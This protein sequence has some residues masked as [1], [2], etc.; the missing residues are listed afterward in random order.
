MGTT[1]GERYGRLVIRGAPR[2]SRVAARR[3]RTARCRRKDRS[4]CHREGGHRQHGPNGPRQRGWARRIRRP[5]G[6]KAIDA[7]R[8]VRD[9]GLVENACAFPRRANSV[10]AGSTTRTASI[11]ATGSRPFETREAVPASKCCP[12]SE[13]QESND[14]RSW[15]LASFSVCGG[16][17]RSRSGTKNT[18]EKARAMVRKFPDVRRELHQDQQESRPVS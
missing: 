1:R 13:G 6:N 14:T 15:R 8:D 10:P 4:T 11:S 9:A 2:S 16:R 18:P 17:S 12:G 5:T 7:A 3:A